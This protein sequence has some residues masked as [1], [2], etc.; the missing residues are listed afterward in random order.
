M[1][2]HN[3]FE[4][5]LRLLNQEKVDFAD[6]WDSKIS[7]KYGEVKVFYISLEKLIEN[8]NSAGRLKDLADVDE[9]DVNRAA[10]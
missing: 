8:K 1:Y 9:L 7:G 5:F 3:D 4:E 2:I 6:A 10:L